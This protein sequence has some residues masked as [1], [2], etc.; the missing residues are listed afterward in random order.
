MNRVA[1]ST[2][3]F[4]GQRLVVLALDPNGRP[5]SVA[6]T[7]DSTPLVGELPARG[8]IETN[9][10]SGTLGGGAGGS[11]GEDKANGHA[12]VDTGG[13]E[14]EVG[15]EPDEDADIPP[16]P[17]PPLDDS[18][19]P[20]PPPRTKTVETAVNSTKK[21]S[22]SGEIVELAVE[23][24]SNAVRG[25]LASAASASAS[26]AASGPSPYATTVLCPRCTFANPTFRGTCEMCEATLDDDDDDE[27]G[28]KKRDVGNG[29][30]SGSNK[31]AASANA[32]SKGV[33]SVADPARNVRAYWEAAAAE[34]EAADAA[35]PTPLRAAMSSR[36]WASISSLTSLAPSSALSPPTAT[37]AVAAAEKTAPLSKNLAAKDERAAERRGGST[38]AASAAAATTAPSRLLS[39]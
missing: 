3:L 35:T 2:P 36:F 27:K 24:R 20:P 33:A 38:Q 37:S 25:E 39:A 17:P 6:S 12:A 26:S 5:R 9:N 1:A 19:T 32:A 31:G 15:N 30:N 14:I 7:D 4:T 28:E 11:G 8:D 34:E 10:D 21:D 29:N 16:P 23:L 18:P 22:G 13:D